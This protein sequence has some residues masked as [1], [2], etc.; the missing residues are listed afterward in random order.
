MEKKPE[1]QLQEIFR[2]HFEE[3]KKIFRKREK[4]LQ[5]RIEELENEGNETDDDD[6]NFEADE[7]VYLGLD[8]F[9]YRLE[10]G[11][12]L[13]QQRVDAFVESLRKEFCI[14]TNA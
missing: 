13:I 2:T 14:G 5:E 3:T 6:E 8:T 1:E 4:E 7:S 11:N 12:L 9:E 10:N